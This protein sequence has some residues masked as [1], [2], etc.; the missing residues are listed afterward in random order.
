MNLPKVRKGTEI[1][2]GHPCYKHPE[3]G[4]FRLMSNNKCVRCSQEH[5]YISNNKLVPHPDGSGEMI[6]RGCASHKALVVGYD[7]K[8]RPRGSEGTLKYYRTH[9]GKACAK[10]QARRAKKLGNTGELSKEDRGK[11]TKTYIEISALGLSVDH[12]RPIS[13]GG[14]DVWWNLQALSKSTNSS[15]SNKLLDGI[16]E[17]P[18]FLDARDYPYE[19]W[20]LEQLELDVL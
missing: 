5:N 13:E 17:I 15:K 19:E 11:T 8:E 14:A 3:D 7:G 1:H 10:S 2:F 6:A 4:G 9:P 12:I 18:C 16:D 20:V